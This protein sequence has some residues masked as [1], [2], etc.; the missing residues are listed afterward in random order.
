MI[1][2]RRRF[3][4]YMFFTFLLWLISPL[5]I[6]DKRTCKKDEIVTIMEWKLTDGAV[7]RRKFGLHETF[8]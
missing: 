2:S 5:S 8:F 7:Y 6:L 1:E 4:R 3:L